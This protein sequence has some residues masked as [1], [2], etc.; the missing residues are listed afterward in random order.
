VPSQA[1]LQRILALL[2]AA[3]ALLTGQSTPNT[4]T[5]P[6]TT[7]PPSS[8]GEA[9]A[10]WGWIIA[11]LL[12][13]AAAAMVIILL[14]RRSR[15]RAV[16]A[17][18]DKT[19]GTVEAVVL[20]QRLLPTSGGDSTPA[21]H[22]EGVRARVADATRLL[23]RAAADAPTSETRRAATSCADALHA[24][25]FAVDADR[26]LREGS[27]TPT[28]S[29]LAGADTAIQQSSAAVLRSLEGL[30]AQVNLPNLPDG[31]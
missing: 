23:E 25:A 5:T 9:S 12:V 22:W 28:G 24:A 18:R 2:L 4:T 26:L 27:R 6:T 19:R 30:R 29:E 16:Q 14:V 17:W 7:I 31:A 13:A 8:S 11:V 3:I 21:A 15:Q 1:E 20:V 10:P